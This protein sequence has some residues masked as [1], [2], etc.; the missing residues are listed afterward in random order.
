MESLFDPAGLA[1]LRARE[2]P[3]PTGAVDALA[4]L[5][6][7]VLL[8][9]GVYSRMLLPHLKRQGIR[10]GWFVD[11]DPDL[12]GTSLQGIEIRSPESLAGAQDRLVVAM[13][14]HLR[15]MA[16]ILLRW[17]VPR[18]VW[19]TQIQDVFGNYDLA[20]RSE[21]LV[22]NPE[23]GR[24]TRHLQASPRS[25]EVL[26]KAL[27]CRVT[28]ESA[29]FPPMTPGQYFQEDLVDRDRWN[30]FVDCGAFTGDTLL[31]WVR[32]VEGV[33][34]ASLSYHALEPDPEN[35]LRL[36]EARASLPE[37]VRARVHLHCC[38]VGRGEGRVRMVPGGLTTLTSEGLK[39]GLDVPIVRLDDLL[40]GQPVTALK[41]DVEGFE[42]HALEGAQSLISASRPVLLIAIYHQVRHLWELPLWIHDLGLGYRIELRHHDRSQSETVCYAVPESP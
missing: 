1:D 30:R 15:A 25:L 27:L 4:D 37:P 42:P 19:F 34:A 26:R 41:M 32:R 35:Y 38:A 10:P 11:S 3:R 28:G 6:G 16:D 12:W 29:D 17:R 5:D 20:A 14:H 7:A 23:I 13:T 31:E 9:A 24:L 36:E 40:S 33:P 2:L 39:E 18:W 21:E 22:G 8:G